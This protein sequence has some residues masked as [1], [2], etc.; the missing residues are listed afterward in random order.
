MCQMVVCGRWDTHESRG[1]RCVV[2]KGV[3]PQN[4]KAQEEVS[5]CQWLIPLAMKSQWAH[6]IWGIGS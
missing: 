2:N 1:V 4:H 6:T 5:R 3:T